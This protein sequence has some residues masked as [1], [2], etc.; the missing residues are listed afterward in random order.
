VH[1]QLEVIAGEI[2][3]ASSR[4]DRLVTGLSPEEWS[5]RPGAGEWSAAECVAHLNLTADGMLPGI[6]TAVEEL[7]AERSPAA[8]R[9]RS[10]PL[11]WVF[12]RL[13]GPLPRI[14][15]RRRGRVSTTAPFEP[16]PDLPLEET[17]ARFRRDQEELLRLLERGEGL[18]LD[19]AKIQSPFADRVS[20]NAYAAF[21]ILVR[22]EHRHLQ[23]AEEAVERVR[24]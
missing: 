16:G 12:A 1:P 11:G 9:Y 2:R 3:R 6:R 19:R 7:E 14:A 10:D 24:G 18:A 21:R 17:V 4:L 20:Y 22:H 15:G 13:V 5:T 8:S 23:Q